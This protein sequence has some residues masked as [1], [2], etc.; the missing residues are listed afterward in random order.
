VQI[1][2]DKFSNGS[3]KRSWMIITK[4]QSN[5]EA[6][7]GAICM[8]IWTHRWSSQLKLEKEINNLTRE[9]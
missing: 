9:R 4:N 7:F 8:F 3:G 5:G 2:N 6:L 1:T